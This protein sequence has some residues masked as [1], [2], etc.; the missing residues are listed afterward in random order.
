MA[1]ADQDFVLDEVDEQE[2]IGK[3]ELIYGLDDRPPVGES[4]FVAFQHVLAAFV[5]IITPP[6]I[7]CSGLG[8]DAEN[9]S[10]LISMSLFASGICTYIQCKKIGP[11]GSGLLSLQG[12]SFAFLGPILGVGTVALQGG[13]SPQEALALIFGVCFFGSFVEIIL[14]RFLHLMSKIITPVVSGTVVMIIGLGLIKTGM[15]SL[16]GGAAALAK[17]DGSFGSPQNLL[18]GGTVLLIVVV[19][20]LSRNR[21]LR[22]GAIAIGLAVGYV[23]SLFLGIV[24]FSSLSTLPFFRIPIPFR[25]GMSFDFG[26]FLP[27]I[28]LYVL[29]AIETV[30]DLTATSAV[31]GQPVRGSTY[32]RRIK[33][34]VLGDGVNSLIAAVFNTFPNT[35]FSQNN[36]VIQMTGVGSRYVGFFVAGI[37]VILGLL[38]IVGGVFQALP[39]PVLGGATLVMFGSIA[40]AGLKIVSSAGLDRRAMIIVAVSLGLGLGVVFVPEVFANQSPL[41]KNLFGSAISTGGLTALLLSWLLP[42]S[43]ESSVRV[44]AQAEFEG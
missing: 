11:V 44:N 21:F 33:G 27:F 1:Q 43:S 30:G 38:P 39:Q 3:S 37:F 41:I 10:Y 23:A 31:S 17:K 9:T 16:A 2:P 6:L 20:T 4:V 40:V 5:G 25:Y 7:I 29:T 28:L 8:L 26:A 22:M 36:G 19:L 34:G 32:V 42:Q 18:L 13:R 35:T 15:I 24:D 12:T 14:S